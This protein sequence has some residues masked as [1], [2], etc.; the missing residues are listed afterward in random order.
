MY[1]VSVTSEVHLWAIL[2]PEMHLSHAQLFEGGN[3]D[4]FKG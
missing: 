3:Y 4:A 1:L 2:A